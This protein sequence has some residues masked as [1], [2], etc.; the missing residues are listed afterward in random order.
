MFNVL[1]VEDNEDDVFL[2]K[3]ALR[4]SKVLINLDVV[5][6]GEECLEL[7]KTKESLPDLILLDINLPKLNGLELL[8]IV[9]AD[10]RYKHIPICVLTTSRSESDIL[11]AY[12]NHASSY[13]CKPVSFKEFLVIVEKIEEFWFTLVK[14]P[15]K[16]FKKHKKLET[17]FINGNKEAEQI[18]SGTAP[19]TI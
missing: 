5:Y 16:R 8:K 18:S 4:D 14:I 2:T 19:I 7:L 6:D 10:N 15:K 17:D 9:K 11:E 1:L 12:T 3:K 13:I